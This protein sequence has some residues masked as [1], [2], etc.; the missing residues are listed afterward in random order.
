MHSLLFTAVLCC[1]ILPENTGLQNLLNW[2]GCCNDETVDAREVNTDVRLWIVSADSWDSSLFIIPTGQQPVPQFGSLRYSRTMNSPRLPRR[3]SDVN[4]NGGALLGGSHG[5]Q[6]AAIAKPPVVQAQ[7]SQR[8][9]EDEQQISLA[10]FYFVMVGIGYLFPFSALTQPVDYWHLLFPDFNIEFPLTT[11]YMYTNLFALAFLVWSSDENPN[12]HR[13]MYGG[14]VGQLIALVLVPSSY[15]LG[16]SEHANTIVVLAATTVASISTAFIDSSV[17]ALA[18]QYPDRVQEYL[19]VGVGV[20]TL[21][22]SFYRDATK[23][24]FP[25]N[26]IVESSLLYFYVGA[27]TIFFCISSYSKL[28]VLPI[29]KSCLSEPKATQSN[30]ATEESTLL[31]NPD[32]REYIHSSKSDILRKI[33]FN[34]WMVFLVFMSTLSLWPPLVTEIKS[35]NFPQLESS[36]WWSLILLSC[37]SVMDCLGRLL[38]RFRLGFTRDTIW[39]AVVAR[40]VLFPLIVGSVQGSVVVNDLFSALLVSALGFTNGY[41]GTLCIILVNE[42]VADHELATAGMFTGFFL[43][44]GLVVGA[45]IG[46]CLDQWIVSK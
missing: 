1:G 35:H 15:F 25:P 11:T 37:F 17:I 24:I 23:I 2:L 12:F 9:E 45:T 26:L 19:Q 7:S 8:V 18:S 40:L 6:H 46:M 5:H 32:S 27:A 22:G 41:V 14:F 20:S 4:S 36:G 38:V 28:I 34:E 39:M 30:I 3:R 16:L 29:S 13:R 10:S 31:P 43:N 21:I 44:S 42:C 33:W